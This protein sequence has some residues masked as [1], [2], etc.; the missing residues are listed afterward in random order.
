MRFFKTTFCAMALAL[1]AGVQAQGLK[2]AYKDYFSVGVAVNMR[3]LS[4]DKHVEIIK[5]N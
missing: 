3:N 4:N 5:S 2:D 1:C